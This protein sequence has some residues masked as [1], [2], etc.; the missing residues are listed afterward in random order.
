[1]AITDIVQEAKNVVSGKGFTD[2]VVPDS[3]RRV[4]RVDQCKVVW[5]QWANPLMNTGATAFGINPLGAL[6]TPPFV[7]SASTSYDISNHI[8]SFTYSKDMDS[9]AGSF[10][11]V[12]H[13]SFDFARFMHPGEWITIYLAQDGSLGLPSEIPATAALSANQSL[14]AYENSLIP[15]TPSLSN[16]GGALASLATSIL[17]QPL[18]QLPL[19]SPDSD[20]LGSSKAK[21]RTLGV[22]TRVGI[23]ST[24]TADGTQETTYTV[25]GRDFGTVYEETEIWFNANN[26]DNETYQS[27][28]NATTTQFQ[29]NVSELLDKWHDLFLNPKKDLSNIADLSAFY[30]EQWL[31]PSTLTDDLGLQFPLGAS[32]FFGEIQDLKEFNATV[33]ENPDANPLSGLEGKCWDRLKSLAQPEFHE[34]FT[35]LSDT[36]HPRLIF[37]PIPWA[38]DKSNY[39]TI[40]AAILNYKDLTSGTPVQPPAPI[41]TNLSSLGSIASAALSVLKSSISDFRVIHSIP[42][43]AIEV[44][45]YDIGPD[46]HNRYNFF[47]ISSSKAGLDQTNAFATIAGSANAKFNFPLRNENNIKRNGF[48]PMIVNVAT[49]L[50]NSGG[51]FNNGKFFSNSPSEEFILQANAMMQDYHGHNQDF[52]SGTITINGRNDIKLGKVIVTDETF[53]GISDMVFY[54]EGYEDNFTVNSDGVTSWTQNLHVTRGMTKAFLNGGSSVYRPS[55]QT[56]TFHSFDKNGAGTGNAILDAAKKFIKSPLG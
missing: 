45:N 22:I 44:E 19:P 12:L 34:L 5:Y 4:D 55:V 54:I 21:L 48:K 24:M 10:S 18:P 1:M 40:G 36:G 23:R 51:L 20:I 35:E 42:L 29:R 7:L 38:L 47:L 2:Q 6:P 11:I 30:P 15:P 50:A 28:V 17:P 14:D 41:G 49:F 32:G 37:R 46:Y 31:M 16:V 33:F 26:A 53:D 39:P 52:Y 27:V 3:D 56:N 13:N 8:E 43:T 9:A 25:T